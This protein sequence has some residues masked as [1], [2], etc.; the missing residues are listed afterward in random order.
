[1]EIVVYIL[2]GLPIFW[3]LAIGILTQFYWIKTPVKP[4]DDTNRINNLISW[5]I[6]LT[7]PEIIAKHYKFFRQDVLQNIE[8]VESKK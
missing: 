8:D 1:M 4:S 2:L 7:R 3:T 5:W 6:G